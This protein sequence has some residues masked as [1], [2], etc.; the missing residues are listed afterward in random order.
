MMAWYSLLPPTLSYIES[1]V[2]H[3]FV[4]FPSPPPLRILLRETERVQI[5]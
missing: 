4:R 3:I 5:N 1:S 2:V